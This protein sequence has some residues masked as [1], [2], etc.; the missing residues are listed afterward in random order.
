M[1][2]MMFGGCELYSRPSLTAHTKTDGRDKS[3]FRLNSTFTLH[4]Q[5]MITAESH[6][7]NACLCACDQKRP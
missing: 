5:E 6:L 7:I 4:T 1:E 3:E 2:L